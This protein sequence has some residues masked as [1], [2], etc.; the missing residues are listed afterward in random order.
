MILFPGL[1]VEIKPRKPPS[2]INV[3]ITLKI[4]LQA[5]YYGIWNGESVGNFGKKTIFW[6]VLL[7]FTKSEFMKIGCFGGCCPFPPLWL[8]EWVVRTRLGW[9]LTHS[10]I[11]ISPLFGQPWPVPNNQTAGQAPLYF[12]TSSLL[13][14]AG[15]VVLTSIY[16]L[17]LIS[18]VLEVVQIPFDSNLKSLTNYICSKL[19]SLI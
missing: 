16:P 3:I 19:L 6:F 11:S 10:T 4:P 1:G 7:P 2:Q 8:V 18:G 15:K 14:V 12:Q 17:F 13:A 9:P 5:T